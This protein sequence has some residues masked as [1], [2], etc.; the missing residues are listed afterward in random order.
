MPRE[1]KMEDLMVRQR[2]MLQK[3]AT[4]VSES[5]TDKIRDITREL[6][7]EGR[8]LEQLAKD[9]ERQELA[10]AGPPPRGSLEVVLTPKQRQH[11][12]NLTGYELASVTI[13]DE[14]GVLSKAMPSTLPG[15]ILI[16]AIEEARRRK[17]Q[18]DADSKMKVAVEQA[19]RDIEEQGMPE[20]RELLEK[21]K[22]DPNWLGGLYH[23]K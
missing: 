20:T 2:A 16:I 15:D 4:L 19:I 1:I 17:A 7:V 21:C 14:T 8:E 23:R 13:A 10:K 6:E 3:A 9:F 12:Y 18:R 22:Q 5:D 11:V